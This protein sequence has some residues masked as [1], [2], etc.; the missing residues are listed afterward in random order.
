MKTPPNK[1]TK[2]VKAKKAQCPHPPTKVVMYCYC[3]EC[4]MYYGVW[5]NTISRPKKK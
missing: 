4:E 3:R 2:R 5:E 1:T